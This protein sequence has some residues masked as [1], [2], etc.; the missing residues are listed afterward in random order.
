[1]SDF[2]E[3]V[4]DRLTDEEIQYIERLEAVFEAARRLLNEDICFYSNRRFRRAVFAE[5]LGAVDAIDRVP[6]PPWP[7]AR[8]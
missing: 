1:M 5:L 6:D 3:R 4:R 2:T 7:R 8:G